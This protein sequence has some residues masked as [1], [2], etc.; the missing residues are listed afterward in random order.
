MLVGQ[1]S[2]GAT[3]VDAAVHSFRRLVELGVLLW[4]DPEV[5]EIRVNVTSGFYRMQEFVFRTY[6]S[7]VLETCDRV[8]M[9]DNDQ[10]NLS[11]SS[12]SSSR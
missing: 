10:E 5:G 11:V 8:R 2:L 7:Y 3:D 9:N 12:E 6:M 4:V 1:L